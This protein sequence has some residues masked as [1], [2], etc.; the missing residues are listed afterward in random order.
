MAVTD[1]F[2]P[3]P[4]EG[5][6]I[7]INTPACPDL[8]AAY[9]T[10]VC[11]WDQ[12]VQAGAPALD[13]YLAQRD[14]ETCQFWQRTC[15]L[16]TVQKVLAQAAT[17]VDG[18]GYLIYEFTTDATTRREQPRIRFSGGDANV[19]WVDDTD[20]VIDTGRDPSNLRWTAAGVKRVRCFM[21]ECKT[22][23][24]VRHRSSRHMLSAVVQGHTIEVLQFQSN[25]QLADLQLLGAGKGKTRRLQSSQLPLAVQEAIITKTIEQTPTVRTD[26][27]L[28]DMRSNPDHNQVDAGLITQLT[29]LG[30]RYL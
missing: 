29:N 26:R 23:R 7:S 15:T 30:W 22:V 11:K 18:L 13:I 8:I 4:V 25:R 2:I 16:P 10:A 21:D 20:T 6:N 14:Y 17:F 3:S 9:Q 27:P 12:L 1:P 19:T 24:L 5:L 28:L